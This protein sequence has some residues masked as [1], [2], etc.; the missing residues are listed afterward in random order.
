MANSLVILIGGTFDPIHRGHLYIADLAYRVLAPEEVWFVP[1]GFPVHKRLDGLQKTE[2]R[3]AMLERAIQEYPH[4][5]VSDIEIV[6]KRPSY[7]IETLK[8]LAKK[9]PKKNFAYLVGEDVA[10]NMPTWGKDWRE[11]IDWAHI[12]F[13]HRSNISLDLYNLIPQPWVEQWIKDPQHLWKSKSGG[14][15]LL[16]A[17]RGVN[18]SA[19]DIRAGL[20]QERHAEVSKWLHPEVYAYINQHKL[21]AE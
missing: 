19:T 16:P 2:H 5:K 13:T 11:L 15:Y 1:C 14:L 4:F 3:M 8:F 7:T 9:Y 17:E 20:M 21:Y 10:R 12:I 6:Q 18:I